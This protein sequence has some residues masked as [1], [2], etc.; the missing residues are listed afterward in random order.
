MYVLLSDIEAVVDF[1]LMMHSR[2]LLATCEYVIISVDD[3]YHAPAKKSK[4]FGFIFEAYEDDS[5]EYL[6]FR[7]V[8]IVTPS[9]PTN[10][11]Y[12][13]FQS[14]VSLKNSGPPFYIPKHKYI[15]PD[16]SLLF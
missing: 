11:N 16:V 15:E 2:L 13:W 8:L 12:S 4:Y 7:S 9:P 5:I 10:R 1:A 14:Q 3:E 6:P